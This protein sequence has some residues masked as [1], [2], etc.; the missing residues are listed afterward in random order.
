MF[1]C[2]PIYSIPSQHYY[3]VNFY[4]LDRSE[5][6]QWSVSRQILLWRCSYPAGVQTID[7]TD[8]PVCMHVHVLDRSVSPVEKIWTHMYNT[9]QN[10]YG[11]YCP[12]RSSIVQASYF[13][14]FLISPDTYARLGACRSPEYIYICDRG[15]TIDPPLCFG[16]RA[17]GRSAFRSDTAGIEQCAVVVRRTP[18]TVHVHDRGGRRDRRKDLAPTCGCTCHTAQ[19]Q[20]GRYYR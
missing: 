9:T 17:Y 3:S 8:L 12:S 14:V 13:L 5:T 6:M 19:T 4:S 10:T 11:S 20:D 15:S 7:D 18:Y 16:A 1:F 2:F